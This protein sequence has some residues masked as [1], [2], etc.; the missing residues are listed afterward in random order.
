MICCL[1]LGKHTGRFLA[2]LSALLG[3]RQLPDNGLGIAGPHQQPFARPIEPQRRR[4]SAVR[5]AEMSLDGIQCH[6]RSA[7]AAA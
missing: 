5:I 4:A 3:L 7:R 2:Q 1:G 6:R